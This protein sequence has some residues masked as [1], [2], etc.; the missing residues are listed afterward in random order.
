MEN[1]NKQKENNMMEEPNKEMGLTRQQKIENFLLNPDKEIF[2]SLQDFNDSI[3]YIKELVGNLDLNDL[4]KLQGEDGHNPELGIDYLTDEDLNKIDAFI[5]D[6]VKASFSTLP[7]RQEIESN[8]EN[9][10]ASEFAKIPT[11]EQINN[12]ISEKVSSEVSNIPK[13]K[14]GSPD[15][16]IQILEKLRSLPKNQRINVS[17]I[18]GL[19]AELNRIAQDSE[20]SIEELRTL[21]NSFQ[22]TIPALGG[23]TSDITGMI[24]A[25]TNISIT[26]SGTITDP[27]IINASG[28]AV[29]DMEK[30]VYDPAGKNSQVEVIA[31]KSTDVSADGSSDIK[32]ST[33]KSVKTYVDSMVAGLLD[34]RG[35]YDASG[36]TYPAAGGSGVA[37]AV[38]KGDMWVVSVAGILNSKTVHVGD[39]IIALVDDPGQTNA[40][41]NTLDTNLGYTPEDQA[42]K[43]T[44]MTGN[45]ASSVFYLTAK[46]VYDWAIALFAPLRPTA[47]KVTLVDADEVT[48]NDSAASFGQIKTTW[49]NVKVFLKTWIDSMTSTFT[50]KTLNDVTNYIDADALHLKCYLNLGSASTIGMPV[51]SKTWNVA[52]TAIEVSKARANAATT[53]PCIGLM[54][55]AGADGTV[56]SVRVS[57]LLNNVDTSAWSEGT[58]LYVSSATAGLLTST[59]PTGVNLVQRIGTVIR[60]H[61]TLGVIEVMGAGRTNDIPNI[62]NMTDAI[63]EAKGADIASATTTDIG[64]ATGNFVD[65]TGTTTI[66]GLGT[67]QAGTRRIVRFTGALLLT[68]NAT[69][70]ILPTSANITTVAGDTA[71]FVSIGSGNWVCTSYQRKDGSAFNVR[72]KLNADRTYYV[73][74]DGNDSN[75]GLVNSSGGAFL[76]IQKAINVVS[77]LDISIYNVTIQ[78]GDGT[79]TATN[80]L[81]SIIGSGTITIQGNITTYDNCLISTTNANCFTGQS[82]VGKYLIQGFKLQTTTNGVGV[83]SQG[84]P[85]FIQLNK[86][87]F[88]N[89]ANASNVSVDAGGYIDMSNGTFII[90]GSAN[91]HYQTITGGTINANSATYTLSGTPAFTIA[92]YWADRMLGQLSC[93][94]TT[95]SGSATG[96]RYTISN[97]AVCF[98]NGGGANYFP[99]NVAG[100]TGTGGIYA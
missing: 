81:K 51:Y 27:F 6:R 29:G 67:V 7:T 36:N 91:S 10:I 32:Y 60:Q 22:V 2:N 9:K 20:T 33:P 64:A 13:A 40:N 66:T 78:V 83:L 35:A 61:A 59:R 49:A 70:L 24:E 82:V 89:I 80:E 53:M 15:T 55:T 69:S 21:V 41:W 87:N 18:R 92:F 34:Y 11:G 48:G 73:R 99:G 58:A 100:T 75:T 44:T 74:T 46:A 50:N 37:G 8:I 79:Y 23:G 39:Y 84:T 90:S 25:G 88:G 52:N 98:T 43:K 57:G 72:E 54:E 1:E 31:N 86:I 77:S 12:S 4:E 47:T 14:D 76:T 5:N 26:G 93:F 65:V 94:S 19:Q 97:N 68:Y 3:N 96:K 28:G 30:S 45:E 16:A 42:N 85:T 62:I 17:D 71:T 95:F 63:N 56:G 38:M